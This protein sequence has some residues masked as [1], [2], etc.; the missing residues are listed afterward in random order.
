MQ[1]IRVMLVTVV[2]AF[3]VGTCAKADGPIQLA[4]W[5]PD[6]QLLAEEESVRGLRLN[7]YGRN[8]NVAG[9]DIGFVHESSGEFKGVAFGLASLVDGG[10]KGFQWTWIYSRAGGESAG[11]QAA[12]LSRADGGLQGLQTSALNLN[13]GDTAGVQIA[14]IYNHAATHISGAQVGLVNRAI[15]VK[16][17]QLGLVN[18]TEQ[19]DGLQLGLWN[20]I[21]AKENWT[22]L[23]IVNWKF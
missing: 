18:L 21:D 4:L 19:L 14:W 13:E 22:I 16:G 3:S 20:Q 8:L 17:L 5:P 15:S 11:W 7:V 23:P 6:V 10:M 9:V 12:V 2:L 1:P